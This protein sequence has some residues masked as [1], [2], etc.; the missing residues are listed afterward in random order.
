MYVQF[1]TRVYAEIPNAIL[2][3]FSTLKILQA[4]NFADFRNFFKAKLEALFVVPADTFDN[5]KGKFPIGFF[6]WDTS[7]KQVFTEFESD[8]YD[9]KATFVG[10][11][12]LL[13][14]QVINQLMI[15]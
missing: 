4:P 8:I 9:T 12:H 6:I 11:K 3:E 2:A 10:K 14:L 15:G 5:V 13:I 7:I 1:F